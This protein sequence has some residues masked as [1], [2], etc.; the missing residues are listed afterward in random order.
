MFI[1][2][3]TD[4]PGL[5]KSPRKSGF[6]LNAEKRNKSRKK[7]PPH[8]SDTLRQL[9]WGEELVY[10]DGLVL[11]EELVLNLVHDNAS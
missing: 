1:L 7:V 2:A 3:S 10:K 4:L 11:D 9:V 6:L 8:Y 5:D